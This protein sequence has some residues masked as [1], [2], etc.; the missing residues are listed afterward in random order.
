M[1][2]QECNE[3]MSPSDTQ[4]KMRAI[5]NQTDCSESEKVYFCDNVIELLRDPFTDR[6]LLDELASDF[7]VIND[8]T[9]PR[10]IG[11][12]GFL[13]FTRYAVKG[14]K[15]PIADN[16][17][18]RKEVCDFIVHHYEL[19][20]KYIG[21]TLELHET[22]TTSY[23]LKSTIAGSKRDLAIKLIKPPYW[24]NP[25]IALATRQYQSALA[26]A[27]ES[28]HVP[29]VLD[30]GDKFIVMEFIPGITLRQFI[31]D[32][33]MKERIK[34][35]RVLVAQLCTVLGDLS[36][37]SSKQK[38]MHHFD[39][40]PDNILITSEMHGLEVKLKVWLIDFGV[41]YLLEEGVGSSSQYE[42]A[43]VYMAPELRQ[44]LGTPDIKTDVFS[45]GMILLNCLAG[46]ELRPSNASDEVHQLRVTY[47]PLGE[48]LDDLLDP[49]AENRLAGV[50]YADTFSVLRTRAEE[51]LPL[52]EGARRNW[53]IDA[54]QH[55][56]V[57]ANIAVAGIGHVFEL[58][59]ERNRIL[60]DEVASVRISRELILRA[61]ACH[62]ALFVI[63]IVC[64]L[65]T[66]NE[67]GSDGWKER[68]VIRLTAIS[69]AMVATKYYQSIF[70][71]LKPKSE[72]A[73]WALW[74]YRVNC[75]VFAIP[76]IIGVIFT[77]W[78]AYCAGSG[79]I[80]VSLNNAISRRMGKRGLRKIEA[81][82][83]GT[84]GL[85]RN[86]SERIDELG[87]W[88]N[89]MAVYGLSLLVVGS[90]L[91]YGILSD[92]LAYALIAGVILNGKMYVYNC[93]KLAA[94]MQAAL[95]AVVYG[96]ERISKFDSIG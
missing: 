64:F 32:K 18:D 90:L 69:F 86:I 42:L 55:T 61:L 73:F 77:D 24:N 68:F 66:K 46:E 87:A 11:A 26:R 31:L 78:W 51:L 38:G 88:T 81:Y 91:D 58:L 27:K 63:V 13:A 21:T 59:R 23:I 60:K 85:N 1:S 16:P 12:L 2:D 71:R 79:V 29:L 89:G 3:S 5:W 37:I 9:D 72:W 14:I 95:G 20:T 35:T 48:L 8:D 34:L 52:Y 67:W 6:V 44:R 53:A 80:I 30:S 56:F 47:P 33:D 74:S 94:K 10:M 7:S 36:T 39:L 19:P 50:E 49:H 43:Q 41:N 75:F 83:H 15:S 40:S 65:L 54:F 22:G 25:T 45:L 96:Y 57:V 70:A 28:E 4:Q 82:Y 93:S 76:I 84:D 17:L 62:L 92:E